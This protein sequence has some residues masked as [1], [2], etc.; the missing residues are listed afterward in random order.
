ML[1]ITRLLLLVGRLSARKPVYQHQ[2]GDCCYS[3]WPL[4]VGLQSLCNRTFSW[5]SCVVTLLF[6]FS[7]DMW[8]FVIE[9]SQIFS[10]F[11]KY[12]DIYIVHVELQFIE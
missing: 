8:D 9:L 10:F 1:L 11:S 6:D 5:H 2:W 3:N 4:L 7:I 12:I